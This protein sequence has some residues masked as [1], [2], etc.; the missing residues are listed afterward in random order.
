MKDLLKRSP[1][2]MSERP[3]E[4]SSSKSWQKLVNVGLEERL[5]QNGATVLYV[6]KSPD[7][8]SNDEEVIDFEDEMEALDAMSEWLNKS[9][10]RPPVMAALDVRKNE[11]PLSLY[12]AAS[13]GGLNAPSLYFIESDVGKTPVGIRWA[14]DVAEFQKTARTDPSSL[15]E[16]KRNSFLRG[17]LNQIIPWILEQSR[18]LKAF[19]VPTEYLPGDGLVFRQK[20]SAVLDLLNEKDLQTLLERKVTGFMEFYS[21]SCSA[22]KKFAPSYESAARKAEHFT[23]ARMDCSTA[24][25]ERS[26][27]KHGVDKYPTVLY[28]AN[29]RLEKY[30]GG[31][32]RDQ[33]LEFLEAQSSP[34]MEEVKT[35]EAARALAVTKP[36]VLWFGAENV[37]DVMEVAESFRQQVKVA[38]LPQPLEEP[39][40][41]RLIWPSS[42]GKSDATY[43]QTGKFSKDELALWLAEQLVRSAP[44]PP[45]Q[46]SPVLTVVGA[47]F[48]QVGQRS[49][50]IPGQHVML[51]VYAPWCGHCKK[52]APIYEDFAQKMRDEGR[53]LV[54]AELDGEANGIPFD[55]FDYTGFPTIFYL[56][57]K[58][59]EIQKV[60]ARSL[61]SLQSFVQKM[62]IPSSLKASPS[63]PSME[64]LLSQFRSEE[65]PS[66]QTSPVLTVVL[67][68]FIEVVF[69]DRRHC[70]LM[71]HDKKC[72][73]CKQMM[74]QPFGSG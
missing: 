53:D 13:I 24:E 69:H 63:K 32:G 40:N 34:L 38:K 21:P 26:C 1:R 64:S 37:N 58:S 17:S 57:P 27:N 31:P 29:G 28:M 22:C 14:G 44:I 52:L 6:Y 62:R 56:S 19:D 73:H 18:R 49:P 25:G 68:N 66:V 65:P 48:R 47:N 5:R 71:L 51:K 12:A 42:S 60:Q 23:L 72:P 2:Q 74:P 36:V 30:P 16:A 4:D 10:N 55:G 61:E 41:L 43:D 33:L 70:I 3:P 35:I 9:C 8:I 39:Q 11:V 54:L 50:E 46:T 59:A 45:E 67:R 20:T 15:M 7:S